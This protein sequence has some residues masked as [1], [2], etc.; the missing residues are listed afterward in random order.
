M[1][2]KKIQVNLI[3]VFLVHDYMKVCIL[4]AGKGTRMGPV[5]KNINK[6][7]LPTQKV[8]C[9]GIQRARQKSHM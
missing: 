7:L 2:K 8:A 1:N 5:D 9:E 6:A 4:T 3:E